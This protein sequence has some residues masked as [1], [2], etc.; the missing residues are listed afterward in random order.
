MKIKTAF[1]VQ[2]T[3][4]QGVGEI[5]RQLE[6]FDSEVVL[7]FA[8]SNHAPQK[9]STLMQ[10]AFPM[11]Q[12]FGCSTAGEIVSGK[13]LQNSIVAMA[14]N[15]KA[16]KDVKLAVIENL[17][18]TSAVKNALASFETYYQEP[19]AEMDPTKYV[20]IILV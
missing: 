5:A 11:S 4:E 17:K 12:V 18:D 13:M 14:F 8:S 10:N 1:S 6:T 7:F 20:G 19:V 16:I 9:V 2:E 3:P 15:G